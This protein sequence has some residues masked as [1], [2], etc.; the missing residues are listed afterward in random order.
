MK[1]YCSCY[2]FFRVHFFLIFDYAA[3]L[4][5]FFI[6]SFSQSLLN[7]ILLTYNIIFQSLY[8]F[9]SLFFFL[10]NDLIVFDEFRIVKNFILLMVMKLLQFLFFPFF[11]LQLFY[12]HKLFMSHCTLF[13]FFFFNLFLKILLFLFIRW[14]CILHKLK[15]FS[16]E[17]CVLNTLGKIHIF[18]IIHARVIFHCLLFK[19]Y[20]FKND[21]IYLHYTT[22]WVYLCILSQIYLS[23]SSTQDLKLDSQNF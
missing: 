23:Q 17:Q 7:W 5:K 20:F 10:H 22:A 8:S 11:M 13:F 18:L 1:F 14:I 16:S 19:I 21:L 4:I 15:H 2:F 12:S 6:F 3:I 9:C